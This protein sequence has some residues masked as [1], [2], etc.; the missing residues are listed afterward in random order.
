[1]LRS[2]AERRPLGSPCKQSQVAAANR[3]RSFKTNGGAGLT[4]KRFRT[5]GE[6]AT[7]V[8]RSKRWRRIKVSFLSFRQAFD[9]RFTGK[10]ARL[11]VL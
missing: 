7:P 6:G 5:R 1:M 4:S 2:N 10:G 8:S 11:A 3:W 9:A